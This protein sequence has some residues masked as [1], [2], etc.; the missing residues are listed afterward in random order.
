MRWLLVVAT[1]WPSAAAADITVRFVDGR[2]VYEAFGMPAGRVLLQ[3]DGSY[4]LQSGTYD[5]EVKPPGCD[6]V[7]VRGTREHPELE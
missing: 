6:V 5:L 4:D 3:L 2:V 7:I 1:A